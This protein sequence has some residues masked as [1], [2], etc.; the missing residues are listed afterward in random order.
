LLEDA[1][2]KVRLV[3]AR[4]VKNVAMAHQMARIIWTLITRQVPFDLSLF[5]YEQKLNEQRRLKRLQ[6]SA[7]QMGYQLTPIAA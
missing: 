1:K 6:S 5:A 2:I 7:R 4:H 3:N